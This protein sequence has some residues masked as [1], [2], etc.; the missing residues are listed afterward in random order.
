MRRHEHF[1]N[2]CAD[3]V[4]TYERKNAD[5]GNSFVKVRDLMPNAILVRLNDKVNRLNSIMTSGNI[6][7]KDESIADTLQDLANYCVMELVEMK[8]DKQYDVPKFDFEGQD[9]T[10]VVI[11]NRY[12]HTIPLKGGVVN[13]TR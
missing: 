4:D 3:M 9:E 10:R 1:I 5:Y 12:G 13:E 6:Q 7:V 8:M 2:I 11:Y